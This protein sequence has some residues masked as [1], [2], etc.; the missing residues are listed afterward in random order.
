MIDK[1]QL[2]SKTLEKLRIII[3]GE[4]T[5]DYRS[6]PVLVAF[7]NEL[8]FNDV[9]GQGFPSRWM[10]TDEKLKII[11]GTPEM[12][13][14]IRNTFAVFNYVGRVSELDALI[15]DFNQYMAFDKWS[16]IR[17]ND[18]I[19]FKRLE[20]VVVDSGNNAIADIKVDDFLKMTFDVNVDTLGLDSRVSQI[21][22][23]RLKEIE[24]CIGG[25]APLAS[26]LLTGSIM[27]GIFLGMATA[28]PQQFNKSFS[29]PKE[30]DTGKVRMFPNWTLNNFIDVSFEVGL[31]KQDVKEFSHV[32]RD[33]RNYIH[34]NEQ[35]RSAFFP[36]NQTAIICFQVLK[37]AIYQIGTFQEK[38]R[39]VQA[40]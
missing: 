19:R 11:N 7:F 38:Q 3:N 27:E 6:G 23:L 16:V 17:D 9:Y 14:C 4:N 26:I 30:K 18:T 8:G 32:V 1:M 12:D 5:I 31:L 40:Q 29:A 2:N 21:I 13:K 28:Y 15:A 22:K 37:A 10:Y 35:L 24:T 36:D 20:K 25:E 33:F 34:P 39:G